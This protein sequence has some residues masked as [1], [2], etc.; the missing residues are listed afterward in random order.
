MAASIKPVSDRPSTSEI[1]V[2]VSRATTMM[3]PV[4][5]APVG[6]ETAVEVSLTM[7]NARRP[8][9]L[10]IVARPTQRTTPLAALVPEEM[11]ISVAIPTL[12]SI[13]PDLVDS[14]VEGMLA[15]LNVRLDNGKKSDEEDVGV[16]LHVTGG[17][18][19]TV[20]NQ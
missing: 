7:S 8:A 15:S 2:S 19:R 3:C 16:R 5:D 9:V 10:D 6:L 14:Y 12:V 20:G 13:D 17:R 11:S 1:V 4:A 18:P